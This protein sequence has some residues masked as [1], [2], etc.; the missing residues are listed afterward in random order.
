M[1]FLFSLFL[2]ITTPEQWGE[3]ST[4]YTNLTAAALLL[5]TPVRATHRP[6]RCCHGNQLKKSSLT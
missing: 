1:H 5:E 4:S 6:S 2:N 3:I